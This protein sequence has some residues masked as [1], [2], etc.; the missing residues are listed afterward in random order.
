MCHGD[1]D[2]LI[3]VEGGYPREIEI[4]LLMELREAGV[5]PLWGSTGRESEDSL[6]FRFDR[7]SDEL[8]GEKVGAFGG[9]ANDDFHGAEYSGNVVQGRVLEFGGGVAE[10]LAPKEVSPPVNVLVNV[11]LSAPGTNKLTF[12]GTWYDGGSSFTGLRQYMVYT[13]DR[14]LPSWEGS[15]VCHGGKKQWKTKE[16]NLSLR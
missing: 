4:R 1:A 5:D 14:L 7:V 8:S 11:H 2:V 3:E 6:R 10:S 16:D 9:W 13:F 15:G 12:S